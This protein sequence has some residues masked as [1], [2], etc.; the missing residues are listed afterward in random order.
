MTQPDMPAPAHSGQRAPG[1]TA[2]GPA[3]LALAALALA[4]LGLAGCTEEIPTATRDELVQPGLAVEITLPYEDFVA[5]SAVYGGYGRAS[6][7]GGG[8]LAHEFGPGVD[9]DGV[10]G[11]GLE[12]ATLVRFAGLPR[13]VTVVDTAGTNRTDTLITFQGASILVRLDTIG[14]VAEGPVEIT[15]HTVS[16]AWDPVSANWRFAVDTIG[17]AMPWSAPGGG[18]LEEISSALWD[19][20]AGDSVEIPVDTALIALWA[21]TTRTARDIRLGTTASGVRLRLRQVQLLLNTLPSVR[22]DTVLRVP[23][24]TV[25]ATFIYDPLPRPPR[26]ALRVGGAPSWRTVLNFDLPR[27]LS[28]YPRICSAVRCPVDLTPEQVSYA[29][30]QLTTTTGSPAFAPSDTLLLDIRMVTAPNFLPKSPLG[31]STLAR[32]G[33]TR[34][35]PELFR[36]PA[37]QVVEIPVTELV[38]DQL[39]GETE[40]GGPVTSTLALLSILEP[41]SIEYAS[42]AG[43]SSSSPPMLRLIL[44]FS[45]GG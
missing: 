6:Q 19:P 9:E 15:A 21:D 13:N 14:S 16:E 28:E 45:R 40:S 27:S 37:G 31:P 23:V 29:G 10:E 5:S 36:P 41:W 12:A 43:R 24:A 22:P 39:R 2:I 32:L 42:F 26:D 11:P 35:F 18:A 34:V 4:A 20:A 38:R 1:A 33:G 30:L 8:F 44:N 17:S 7:L 3:A 25:A